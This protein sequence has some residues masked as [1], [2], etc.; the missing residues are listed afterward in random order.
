MAQTDSLCTCA[1]GQHHT[2]RRRR[3]QSSDDSTSRRRNGMRVITM[4]TF[5]LPLGPDAHPTNTCATPRHETQRR[6]QGLYDYTV[7]WLYFALRPSATIKRCYWFETSSSLWTWGWDFHVVWECCKVY[8]LS[9]NPKNH[10][11]TCSGAIDII[12]GRGYNAAVVL[13]SISNLLWIGH[14]IRDFGNFG[15]HFNYDP[16]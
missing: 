10:P 6:K 12:R 3:Q 15:F 2:R 1:S 4:R 5:P 11:K 9:R 16:Q 8:C 7:W 14:R 13:V